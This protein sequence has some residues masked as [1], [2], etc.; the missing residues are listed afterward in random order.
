MAFFAVLREGFETAVFLLAA[1]N[2]SGSALAAGF[3]ALIGV[4]V[5]AAMGYGI[6]RGGVRINLSRFFRITGAVLV[7]VAAGLLA[8]AFHT[9]HEAGW[10]DFG[11]ATVLDLT[12]LVRP[13]SI[14]AS[15]LTGVLGL[16]PRPTLIESVVWLLYLVPMLLFVLWPQRRPAPSAP[17]PSVSAGSAVAATE[18]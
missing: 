13:G 11:Q 2:A 18:R 9:A 3:G 8:T 5:A 15:L 7:V 1:F 14:Q 17:P 4:L 10:I 16:Q 6:Y 12:W